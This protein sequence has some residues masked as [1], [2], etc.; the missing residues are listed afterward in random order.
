MAL[1]FFNAI[2]YCHDGDDHN[3][4]NDDY[5]DE[6]DDDDNLPQTQQ[7]EYKSEQYDS[8]SVLSGEAEIEKC[9]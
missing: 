3:D 9:V 7:R 1:L 8:L 2:N 4:T 6:D 5:F